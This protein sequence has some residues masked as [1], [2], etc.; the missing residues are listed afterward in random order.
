MRRVYAEVREWYRVADAKGQMLLTI[1]GVFVT[2]LTATILGS[3]DEAGARAAVFGTDTWLLAVFTGAALLGSISCATLCLRSRLGKAVSRAGQGPSDAWW[4]GSIA[5]L[6]P[7]AF[8]TMLRSV[9]EDFE[10]DALSHE[11][12]VVSRNVLVKHRWANRGW[13]LA[14]FALVGLLGTTASYLVRVAV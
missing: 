1:D 2:V 10:L 9:D 6:D 5:R 11:I 8:N 7:A 4:F 14:A 12:S 3:P 13:L